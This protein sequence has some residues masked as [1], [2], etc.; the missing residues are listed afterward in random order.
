MTVQLIPFNLNWSAENSII[1]HDSL[2]KRL[3]SIN[4]WGYAGD[5]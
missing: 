3:H 5:G 2:E 4:M 1:G